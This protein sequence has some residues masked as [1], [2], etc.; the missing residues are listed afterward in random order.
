MGSLARQLKWLIAIRLVVIT[1]VALPAFLFQLSSPAAPSFHQLY[2]LAGLTYLASLLY[3]SLLGLLRRRLELQAYVQ[4]VGDLLLVTALVAG[5][6]GVSSPFSMLYL[7]VVSVASTLLRRRAGLFV[8]RIAWIL[9]AALL[10]GLYFGSLDAAAPIETW[11]L[12]YNLSIHAIGF[13]AVARLTSYLAQNVT[14]A[15]RELAELEAFSRDVI[16]SMTS[17]LITTDLEDTIISVNRAGRQILGCGDDEELIGREI[18]DIGVFD[19]EAWERLRRRSQISGRI[20]DEV[21]LR[22]GEEPLCIGFSVSSLLDEKGATRGL[23]LIFQDLTDWRKL[24]EEVQLKE[25]M[26]AV[27]EMAAGLAH[28]IGNP[29]AAIS[30]SVQMLART[31][32]ENSAQQRLLDIVLAESRRLDRT[33]KSFLRYARPKERS[34][35]RFDIAEL[36]RENVELLRNSEEVGDEHHIELELDP[37]SVSI[38]ADRDQIS[39]IFWNLVRNALRAMPEGGALKVVGTLAGGNRYTM[40]V[41]DTGRGMSSDERTNLFHPFKSFFDGGTGIGMAIVYRIVEEHGGRISV[42]TAAGMGTAIAV[43]LPA[44]EAASIALEA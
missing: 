34:S 44:L 28:E 24:Q 23:I 21:L 35:V 38:V 31:S 25:R 6:G 33:I 7:I 10:L 4:F 37:D 1:S 8:A 15:E 42:E 3:I 5:S 40:K 2:F 16:E 13:Y 20:R 39:Q 32:V 14:R 29:L 36:L 30:G 11:R 18:A 41:V 26:A 9:Y 27:G 43:E 12:I 19:A 22:R 17:G